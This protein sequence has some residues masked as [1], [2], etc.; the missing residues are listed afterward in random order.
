MDERLEISKYRVGGHGPFEKWWYRVRAVQSD[1]NYGFG[2]GATREAAC[3][4]ALKDLARGGRNPAPVKRDVS[5]DD[6]GRAMCRDRSGQ[7]YVLRGERWVRAG[8]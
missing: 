5:V 6:D 7:K 2:F 4:R 8:K 1:G 3:K